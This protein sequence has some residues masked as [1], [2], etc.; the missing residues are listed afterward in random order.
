MRSKDFEN[1]NHI[2]VALISEDQQIGGE[3]MKRRGEL[4]YQCL[5]EGA[6]AS[7][8]VQPYGKLKNQTSW[9][10]I[11]AALTGEIAGASTAVDVKNFD[12]IKFVASYLHSKDQT[13]QIQTLTPSAAPSSGSWKIRLVL[14]G[15]TVTTAALAH[16][17]NAAAI[18]AAIRLLAGFHNVTVAGTLATTVVITMAGVIIDMAVVSIVESTLSDGAAVTVTPAITTPF[19]AGQEINFIASS[20]WD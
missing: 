12:E 20:F 9:Q 6:G 15:V 7:N 19:V 5:V 16:N 10:A 8:V 1:R 14:N 18:Q 11:G 13:V 4:R 17:A 2:K 3:T